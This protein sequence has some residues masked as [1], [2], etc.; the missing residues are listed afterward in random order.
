[1]LC[2]VLQVMAMKIIVT[3]QAIF[4]NLTGKSTAAIGNRHERPYI[5]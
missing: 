4:L 1:M 5:K 2:C 3:Q